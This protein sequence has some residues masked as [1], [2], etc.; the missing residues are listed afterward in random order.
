MSAQCIH[1]SGTSQW[2]VVADAY[3]ALKHPDY[4]FTVTSQNAQVRDCLRYGTLNRRILRALL[5]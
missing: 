1:K 3:K 2:E 4:V 5:D